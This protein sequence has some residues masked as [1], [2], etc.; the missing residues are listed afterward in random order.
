[1]TTQ[2]KDP[3][4]ANISTSGKRRTIT[5][6]NRGPVR[7]NEDDWQIV[8]QG[9]QGDATAGG[10]LGWRISI[11]VRCEHRTPGRFIVHASYDNSSELFD[12]RVGHLVNTDENLWEHILA[13]GQ[14][15]RERINDQRMHSYVTHAV[16]SCFADFSPREL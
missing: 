6:T 12:V 9:G 3:D 11:R 8:A 2:T 1:M 16:D 4:D 7:I 5:L 13:V 15:L 10:P 14:E